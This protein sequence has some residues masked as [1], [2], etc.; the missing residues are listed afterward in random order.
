M[1]CTKCGNQLPENSK[2]CKYCG[3]PVRRNQ[4]LLERARNQEEDALA[5]IYNQSSSA[6]YRVIKVL[7]KDEDTVYDILQDTYVKAF[8]RLDQLQDESKLVPWL[9]MIA[10]NTAKDWLKKC[11]P[12]LFTDMSG[13]N[14]SDDLSFE[15]S[16]EDERTDLNPEMAM[17]EKEV[18]R[19]VLEI[20]DQLPEDQRLVIGMFYYE[21]MSVKDIAFTLGVS[22][23]TV[24]SRLSYGRK[25]VK[26][27]VLDLEKKGTKLYT[28]APFAFFLYLL[29][30][31]ESAPADPAE[32]GVLQSVMDACIEPAQS[33]GSWNTT[34]TAARA[35]AKAAGAA[36]KTAAR[37][38]SMKVAA[39]VLTG[40][41]GAG[42]VYG[43]V[44]NADRLPF[45]H[46]QTSESENESSEEQ[47][48]VEAEPTKEPE[49]TAEVTETPE[50]T[51]SPEKKTEASEET[52]TDENTEETQTESETDENTE[53]TQP[54]SEPDNEQE[55]TAEDTVD[56]SNY[57]EYPMYKET[58]ESMASNLEFSGLNRSIVEI[59]LYDIDQ[60]G[61]N[62]LLISHGTCEA[63]WQVEIYTLLNG[64]EVSM[65]GTVG[66]HVSLYAAPDG[67]GIYSTFAKMG[68]ES[69]DRITKNG[70]AIEQTEV[71]AS[72]EIAPDAE[73][74]EY[75]NPIR[76]FNIA[77][78]C[79]DGTEEKEAALNLIAGTWYTVGGMPY[80]LKAEF[81]GDDMKA[82]LPD[83]AEIYFERIVQTVF[84]TSYGYFYV[85]ADSKDDFSN[86]YGYRLETEYPES[87]YII[88]TANPF[89]PAESMTDS[90]CRDNGKLSN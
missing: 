78:E 62:E 68:Y 74:T 29:R 76:F 50:P 5:E 88:D 42:G 21:E 43:V 56:Y 72:H 82:Y 69:A 26:E 58:F 55:Q 11:K 66:S 81:S 41:V 51:E 49:E 19:L 79:Y 20:L 67:N 48:P 16:I 36:G 1:F 45:I 52:K 44:K 38:L 15:E 2:F 34:G 31:L 4:S 40:A 84:K 22:D 61:T 18:R 28:A 8:T 13:D 75:D 30:R 3:N 47:K 39:I 86:Q 77:Q 17:D 25:K 85:I 7:V 89:A 60:D 73:Y 57:P 10:N 24:K 6:V 80:N 65:I 14:E 12:V 64:S 32:M 53:E 33:A 27:L 9:K 46:E 83:S 54:E 37:H 59:A 87:M 90:L 70:N 23:N 71:V 63:D 35:G